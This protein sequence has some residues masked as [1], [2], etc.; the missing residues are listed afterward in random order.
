MKLGQLAVQAG[1]RK[2]R[3]HIPAPL[4]LVLRMFSY[5]RKRLA[6]I[7]PGLTTEVGPHN[8][9]IELLLHLLIAVSVGAP[10]A[11]KSK[12]VV[13]DNRSP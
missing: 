3:V 12:F 5:R 7:C 2:H 8:D 9:T 4:R 13:A 1:P 11:S 6:E 10:G